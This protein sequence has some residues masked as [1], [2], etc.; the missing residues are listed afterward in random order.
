MRQYVR[1][2]REGKGD[3]LAQLMQ[4]TGMGRGIYKM[5]R[6]FGVIEEVQE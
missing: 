2:R 4:L 5:A 6:R 1:L 3:D